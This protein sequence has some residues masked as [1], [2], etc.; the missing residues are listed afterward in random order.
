[1]YL[2]AARWGFE[3]LLEQQLSGYGYR[4]HMIGIL[5]ALRAV[6]HSLDAHDRN[7][8]PAHKNIIGEW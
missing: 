4:F 2:K 7:P 5:A 3:S 1:M 8:S 6:Q